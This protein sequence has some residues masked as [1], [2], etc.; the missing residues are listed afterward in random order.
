MQDPAN[1]KPDELRIASAKTI[2]GWTEGINS[3]CFFYDGQP[4]MN[5]EEWD[6]LNNMVQ[7]ELLF[8]SLFHGDDL[9]CKIRQEK[10]VE[11]LCDLVGCKWPS[12]EGLWKLVRAT[13]RQQIVAMLKVYEETSDL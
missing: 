3:K 1:M 5:V 4:T 12:N 13:P 2:F 8:G 11:C 9:S 6:P 10:Y 7:L